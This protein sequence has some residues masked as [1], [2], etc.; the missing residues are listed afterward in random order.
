[1][2]N[3]L[4]DLNNTL[5]EQ[6]ERLNDDNIMADENKAKAERERAKSMGLI[7]SQIIDNA[8]VLLE[9]VNTADRCGIENSELPEV[10]KSKKKA[11]LPGAAK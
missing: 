5:F 3:S 2:K 9:A 6:L 1:M 8:R 7:A 10:L 11:L 4:N